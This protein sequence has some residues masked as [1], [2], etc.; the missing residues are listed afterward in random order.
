VAQ[1][2]LRQLHNAKERRKPACALRNV[3][4]RRFSAG[5]SAKHSRAL[6]RVRENKFPGKPAERNAESIPPEGKTI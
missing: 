4:E 2:C 6:E 5:L 1:A 3:E